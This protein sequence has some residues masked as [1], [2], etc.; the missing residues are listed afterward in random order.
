MRYRLVKKNGIVQPGMIIDHP[1]FDNSITFARSL[2]KDAT[3][4]YNDEEI[5]Y[6]NYVAKYGNA[7]GSTNQ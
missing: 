3:Q 4:T 5:I 6:S 2:K 7:C 1:Y